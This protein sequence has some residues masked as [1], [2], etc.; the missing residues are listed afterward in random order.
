MKI[1]IVVGSFPVVSET[2][3]VNQITDLIDRGHQ[4]LIF[5]YKKN[6]LDVTHQK[7]ID[8]KL[9]EKVHYAKAVSLPLSSRYIAFFR[10]LIKNKKHIDYRRLTRSFHLK[11]YE[12]F[13]WILDKAPFDIIHVH[14]GNIAIHIA[15]MRKWGYLKNTGFVTS[16]HGADI[17]PH[18][19]S[20]NP[21]FYN[22]LIR[23]VDLITVNSKYT[24]T[25]LQ[26]VSSTEKVK[27]LPV[28]LDSSFFIKNNNSSSGNF[29]VL[30]V[31]RLIALKGPNIAIQIINKLVKKGYRKIK[32][33]VV[34]EGELETQLQEMLTNHDL[35][36]NVQLRGF[37]SQE[38][39]V[40]LMDNSDIFLFPG[41]FDKN[42]RVETQGLVLQEAQ[43]MELPVII[44][45][46]GGMKYG[47]I[48]G[49]TG[50]VVK[51][52]DINAFTDKIEFFINNED[53]RK[54]MGEKARLFVVENFDSK[55][56]GEKLVK[57]YQNIL[58]EK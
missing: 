17:S 8:Y 33:V 30:F 18:L 42:G 57:A 27:I 48:D 43:S 38:N 29:T 3:I 9:L 58:P 28:G 13:K 11:T 52:K 44:S 56:L 35:N 1:A 4:V 40:E 34:G 22:D 46:V 10:F 32:L 5:A 19:I 15:E 37:L 55:V 36:E 25:L 54:E 6:T 41:I 24:R 12:K 51:E 16:F 14:F 39:I 23:E 31:G 45:D 21:N 49:E 47:V 53:K 26:K 50:F 20:E 7:I 2:F